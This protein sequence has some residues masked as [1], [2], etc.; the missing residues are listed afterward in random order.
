MNYFRRLG[1][2]IDKAHPL[3]NSLRWLTTSHRL[4]F[5]VGYLEE[6]DFAYGVVNPYE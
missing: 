5:T 3:S 2:G 6:F 4:R 1:L